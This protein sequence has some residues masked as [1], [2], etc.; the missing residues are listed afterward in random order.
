MFSSI[1]PGTQR[2]KASPPPVVGTAHSEPRSLL[3]AR[4]PSHGRSCSVVRGSEAITQGEAEMGLYLQIQAQQ[5][6]SLSETPLFK[7]RSLVH[8][9]M[10]FPWGPQ[11]VMSWYQSLVTQMGCCLE[12]NVQKQA[13]EPRRHE[14]GKTQREAERAPRGTEPESTIRPASQ[15]PST[16]VAAELRLL[17]SGCPETAMKTMGTGTFK[18]FLFQMHVS[19]TA[20]RIPCV[21]THLHQF[22][23]RK[24]S[25][26]INLQTS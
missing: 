14:D 21:D 3:T 5:H 12:G 10:K 4:L 9:P 25:F 7:F 16:G 15:S 17:P 26:P 6:S 13:A 2:V 11:V 1:P 20:L 8:K 19:F 24:G 23:L 18:H 22:L